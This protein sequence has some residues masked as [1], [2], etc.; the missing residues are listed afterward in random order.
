MDKF[1]VLF[2]NFGKWDFMHIFHDLLFFVVCFDSNIYDYDNVV[3]VNKKDLVLKL[4]MYFWVW[5]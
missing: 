3:C 4:G 5:Q 2:V 1:A